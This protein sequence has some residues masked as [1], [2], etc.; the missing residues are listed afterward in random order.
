MQYGIKETT[1]GYG[2]WELTGPGKQDSPKFGHGYGIQ[3]ENGIRDNQFSHNL[4]SD[5][6]S[7]GR[8]SR[9]SGAG[10][11]EEDPSWT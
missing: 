10:I 11:W 9:E 2:I 4:G 1:T 6:R 5:Y 8:D 7:S 3:K